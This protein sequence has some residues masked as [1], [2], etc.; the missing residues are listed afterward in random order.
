MVTVPALAEVL[1]PVPSAIVTD[2]LLLAAVT[3]PVAPEMVL[4]MFCEEPLSV[5]VRLTEA[6]SPV[7]LAEIPSLAETDAT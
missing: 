6:P 7:P 4:K 1:I 3:D 2:A 5:L